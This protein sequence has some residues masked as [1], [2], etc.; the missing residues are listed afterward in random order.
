MKLTLYHWSKYPDLKVLDPTF[1]GTGI[2]GAENKR[3]QQYPQ[4]YVDRLYFGT[5]DYEPETGL[6][7]YQYTVEVDSKKIYNLRDD[8]KNFAKKATDDY[9]LF[10]ITKMEKLIKK[11]G[12]IGI[13][14]P[15]YP[16][17]AI[18]NPIRLKNSSK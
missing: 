13:Y 3:K 17:V 4:Y 5:K 15:Q 9:G 11:A 12:Y 14:N 7:P 18:F 2:K 6:G 10:N 1:H 16:V 8:L